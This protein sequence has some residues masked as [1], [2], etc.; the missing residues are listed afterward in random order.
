MTVLKIKGIRKWRVTYDD[1]NWII[2]QKMSGRKAP[3]T[4]VNK[5]HFEKL[6]NLFITLLELG[7]QEEKFSDFKRIINAYNKKSKLIL[8]AI[9][10]LGETFDL[11]PPKTKRI[12]S[13]TKAVKKKT[14][15]KKI[16]KK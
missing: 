14:K 12:Q 4:W 15:Q 5:Y 9:E 11:S 1:S 8:D 2:Q 7:V 16:K 13:V 6:E 3:N 10:K